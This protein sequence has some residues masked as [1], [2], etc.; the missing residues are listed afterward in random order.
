[1]QTRLRLFLEWGIRFKKPYEVPEKA[2]CK[3]AYAN[4][5]ELEKAILKKHPAPAPSRPGRPQPRFARNAP[6]FRAGRCSEKGRVMIDR[7]F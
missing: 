3:V 1:M 5:D 4:K 2:Q 7:L 6:R